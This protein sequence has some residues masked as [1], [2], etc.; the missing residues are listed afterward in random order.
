M[1]KG[2][3]E[4]LDAD[5]LICL[6]QIGKQTNKFGATTDMPEIPSWSTGQNPPKKKTF[7]NI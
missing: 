3:P 2:K 6:S 5:P 1:C 4:E 7:D